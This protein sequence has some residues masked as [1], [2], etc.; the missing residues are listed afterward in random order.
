[1]KIQYKSINND[2]ANYLKICFYKILAAKLKL[3]VLAFLALHTFC[4][5]VDF[6]SFKAK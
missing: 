6:V 4:S 2:A 1:M 3:L 5:V